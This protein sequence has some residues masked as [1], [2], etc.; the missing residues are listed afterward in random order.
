MPH[1]SNKPKNNIIAHDISECDKIYNEC[2][3]TCYNE[4]NKKDNVFMKY[5]IYENNISCEKCIYIYEKCRKYL[6]LND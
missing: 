2:L 4:N 5:Y 6:K 1:H 3:K